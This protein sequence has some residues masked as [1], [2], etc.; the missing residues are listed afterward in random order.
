MG[1]FRNTTA[2]LLDIRGHLIQQIQINGPVYKLN[3]GKL[4]KGIY[5][6]KTDDGSTF[7]L[8]KQ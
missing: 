1:S 3:M 5:F 8:I 4:S 7:K 6:L 2:Q